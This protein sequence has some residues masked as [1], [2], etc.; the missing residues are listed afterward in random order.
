M[1]FAINLE[2]EDGE[3][4]ATVGDPQNLLHR[5]L[6]RSFAAEPFL[7][8]IDWYGDTTFN[9]LQ[10]PRFLS[11]WAELAKQSKSPEET[12]L[13]HEVKQL[14]EHCQG[15]VHLYLKFIGD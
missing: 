3:V 10:M 14:A 5:L 8:E 12:K 6:E 2:R 1:G 7:S 15:S 9:R 4:L 11:G 13:V